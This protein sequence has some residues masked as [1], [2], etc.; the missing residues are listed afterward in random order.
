MTGVRVGVVTHV[1]AGIYAGTRGHEER[2]TVDL[3]G[4]G[5]LGDDLTTLNV[6]LCVTGTH[7]S[8]TVKLSMDEAQELAALLTNATTRAAVLIAKAAEHEQA[9]AD[10]TA[11]QQAAMDDL[12]KGGADDARFS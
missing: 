8:T 12:L 11:R 3:N 10:L 1:S 7:N 9:H 5:V 4:G 2:V 6:S